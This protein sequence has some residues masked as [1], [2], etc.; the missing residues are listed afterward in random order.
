MQGRRPIRTLRLLVH[1]QLHQHPRHRL[2][3]PSDCRH[4]QGRH[5]NSILRVLV[6]AQHHQHLFRLT[7]VCRLVLRPPSTLTLLLRISSRCH[8]TGN[9]V[10]CGLVSFSVRADE[11]G[12][13]ASFIGDGTGV[14][15]PMRSFMGGGRFVKRERPSGLPCSLVSVS[16]LSQ[17][18]KRGGAHSETRYCNPSAVGQTQQHRH[19][20]PLPVVSGY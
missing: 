4:V 6:R 12:V 3:L 7:V 17:G 8:Q 13:N 15:S 2:H 11:Y 14:G 5:S 19:R 10:K 9:R 1:A 18:F 20:Y 16:S